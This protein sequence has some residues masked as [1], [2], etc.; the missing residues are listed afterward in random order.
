MSR[1]TWL[2]TVNAA[3]AGGLA[4]PDGRRRVLQTVSKSYPFPLRMVFRGLVVGSRTLEAP[5]AVREPGGRSQ[6]RVMRLQRFVEVVP[7]GFSKEAF[8]TLGPVLVPTERGLEEGSVVTVALDVQD[9]TTYHLQPS[10]M[11]ADLVEMKVDV[12]VER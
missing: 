11:L 8:Q 3:A 4:G 2:D 6:L 9:P 10:G 7:E 1:P 12:A 5:V